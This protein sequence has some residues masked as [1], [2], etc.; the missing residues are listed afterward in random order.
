MKMKM[1]KK[2]KMKGWNDLGDGKEMILR[3]SRGE[4]MIVKGKREN[5]DR[6]GRGGIGRDRLREMGCEGKRKGD[7]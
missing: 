4:W 2:K 5:D 6:G 1:R 3:R 7:L